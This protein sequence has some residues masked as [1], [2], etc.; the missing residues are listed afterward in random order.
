MQ[1][2][3]GNIFDFLKE[4]FDAPYEIG[5]WFLVSN[6]RIFRLHN[7]KQ[8]SINA[9]GHPVVI[10]TRYNPG[11][12]GPN[13]SGYPR[14]TTSRDGFEHKSHLPHNGKT[15]CIISKTGLVLLHIPVSVSSIEIS[16]AT[17]SCTEEFNSEL[18]QKIGIAS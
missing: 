17:F 8:F 13:V 5:S 6:E 11:R 12:H 3:S 2:F 9:G 7:L 10:R 14:S 1:S 18:M 15:T 4:D 16:A